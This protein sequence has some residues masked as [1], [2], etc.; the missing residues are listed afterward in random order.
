V[1]K[2]GVLREEGY[3]RDKNPNGPRRQEFSWLHKNKY[4][5]AER[6]SID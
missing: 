1:L 2:I 4:K 3:E 6:T 5:K